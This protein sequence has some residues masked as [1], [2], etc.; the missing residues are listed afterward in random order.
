ML[1]T[2]FSTPRSEPDHLLPAAGGTLVLALLLPVIA[3]LGWSIEGWAL[4]VVL[5]S[6]LHAI[7]Y[8]LGRVRQNQHGGEAS[9]ALQGFGLLFKLITILVVLFAA[10]A[11]DSG[12][13]V[14]A[15]LAYGLAYTFELGLSLVF[16]FGAAST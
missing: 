7:E 14:V 9:P 11:A 16:Y 10:L 2:I 8:L 5:W 3:L 1:G 4:A 13:A 15:V 12:V 6:G